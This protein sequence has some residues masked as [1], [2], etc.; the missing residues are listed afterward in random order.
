LGRYNKLI[1][2]PGLLG[3][4]SITT[5]GKFSIGGKSPLTRGAKESDVGGEV[6][7][8]IAALGI[9]ALVLEELPDAPSTRVLKITAERIEL[10]EMPELKGK[11][12]SE[13]ILALRERFGGE[14][15]LL[16]IG[17]AGEMKLGGA[18]IAVAGRQDA[19]VRY[20]ARGGLGAVLGAKGIKA[21]V[22]DDAGAPAMAPPIYDPA[23]L[24]EA[25]KALVQGIMAD[26]KTENRHVYGTPAV[27]TM[28]NEI[29]ILPTRNFS[30]G[31]F[32]KADEICGD[33]IAQLIAERGGDGR[34]GTPCVKGCVIACSNVF[35]DPAGKR[36]VASIQ[37]ENIALLGPNCGIGDIDAIAELNHLCNEVGV[38]AIETGAAIG[39]AM[40]AGVVPF[41]DAE[42]AKDL[43]RQIGRGTPLGRI[44]GSGVVVT[45]KVF[46][47]R[48][49]P[50]V[51]GQ[52]IPAYDPRS[53][54]GNGVTYVTSPM[55]ADHTAGN[56]LE[57]AR[58]INPLGIEQQ[59]EVSRKLQIRGAI[60]DTMGLCLFTRP[61]FTKQPDLFLPLLKG[62]YGWDLAYADVQRMG[63]D[64]LEAERE[65]NRRSG[66]GEEFNDMPEFMREE[67]LPPMDSVY[68]VP[69]AE[70]QRIWEVQV[71]ENVF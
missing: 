2:A 21:I 57:T 16:C 23:G 58:T 46:G 19:Q 43:L 45:G 42:G 56:M 18:G 39:V 66:A 9:K 31:R 37:Y 14:A 30:A 24:R 13:T 65:F 50:A 35:P 40:E 52:A 32:E 28:C 6:G 49:V 38:D 61:P 68:D 71:P 12:V 51:K 4:S 36:I 48:R 55:G 22:V 63:I 53:L 54:K 17:P 44:I 33:R 60:L 70:M 3:D 41:G 69:L 25:G 11:L 10:A 15:G 7:R 20:A 34:S 27:L 62:R 5:T 26:P 59:V 1:I 8:K 67:P 64:T 29:G 47:V